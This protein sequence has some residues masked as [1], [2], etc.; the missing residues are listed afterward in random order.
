MPILRPWLGL[1]L[2]MDIFYLGS[3]PI[4]SMCG[5]R[6]GTFCFV[7]HHVS[8]RGVGSKRIER[9]PIGK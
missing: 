5:S 3:S 2:V 1:Y 4:P 8:V 7:V 9:S 6:S